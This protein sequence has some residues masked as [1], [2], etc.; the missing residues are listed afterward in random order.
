[1][2]G[3]PWFTW[4]GDHTSISASLMPD[5]QIRITVQNLRSAPVTLPR[6]VAA[7]LRDWLVDQELDGP[8]HEERLEALRDIV[9]Q[10]ERDYGPLDP[11][12]LDEVHRKWPDVVINW[13]PP[14]DDPERQMPRSLG[15][16][17]GG[18]ADLSQRDGFGG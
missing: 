10:F 11:T 15:M 17:K 6:E 9:E 4:H 2:A 13:N 16:G 3:A 14:D 7:N 12:M 5:G 8:T 18:P 1:M